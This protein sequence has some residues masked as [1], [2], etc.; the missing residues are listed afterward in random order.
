MAVVAALTAVAC[1]MVEALPWHGQR[2]A[3]MAAT[4]S[5]PPRELAAE[6]DDAELVELSAAADRGIEGHSRRGTW[7]KANRYVG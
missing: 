1:R 6:R 4:S 2:T 7:P 3:A 5:E